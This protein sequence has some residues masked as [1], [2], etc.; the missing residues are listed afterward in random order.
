[1]KTDRPLVP[2][3][4]G[5]YIHRSVRLEAFLCFSQPS[6]K[7]KSEETAHWYSWFHSNFETPSHLIALAAQGFASC[8]RFPIF[9][10]LLLYDCQRTNANTQ[11][12]DQRGGWTVT[13]SWAFEYSGT[14]VLLPLPLVIHFR[15]SPSLSKLGPRT[16][17]STIKRNKEVLSWNELLRI[18]HVQKT[19]T[20]LSS[21]F[22]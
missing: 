3:S 11:S 9:F 12:T 13:L 17:K 6:Y 18:L 19:Y 15:H 10:L 2:V 7:S 5:L 1:M 4:N 20:L 22:L 16:I 14:F 8:L 21:L